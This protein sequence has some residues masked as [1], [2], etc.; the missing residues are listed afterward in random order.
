MAELAAPSLFLF[1]ETAP[2]PHGSRAV[3][4]C[5]HAKRFCSP[6]PKSQRD[7]MDTGWSLHGIPS[8]IKVKKVIRVRPLELGGTLV[9]DLQ[10]HDV[11]YKLSCKETILGGKIN[12]DTENKAIEYK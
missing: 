12:L 3:P 10:T 1:R 11:R 4:T 2:H 6:A 9:W 7:R 5:P 8:N